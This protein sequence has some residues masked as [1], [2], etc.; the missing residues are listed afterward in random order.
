MLENLDQQLQR[1]RENAQAIVLNKHVDIS[2][3]NG[4]KKRSYEDA[5][6]SIAEAYRPSVISLLET[7][8]Q[9]ISELCTGIGIP[10]LI[11]DC[12]RSATSLQEDLEEAVNVQEGHDRTSS[13]EPHTMNVGCLI[14]LRKEGVIEYLWLFSD[15]HPVNK[16]AGIQEITT[17][18]GA[19]ES[20]HSMLKAYWRPYLEPIIAEQKKV[21]AVAIE[22]AQ[23][24]IT[25]KE[26]TKLLRGKFPRASTDTT[27]DIKRVGKF[28]QEAGYSEDAI[29][30]GDALC[31][32][33]EQRPP[34]TR[35]RDDHI[36]TEC[37]HEYW[38]LEDV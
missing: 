20:F 9:P 8:E 18:T 10:P 26:L 13:S 25:R 12:G 16:D 35:K 38:E 14:T 33:E 6:E 32:L 24:T 15:V 37:G 23:D 22:K 27:W 36:D 19:V 5:K 29:P 21:E 31:W 34:S 3:L 7:Y 28:V 17:T 2:Q 1:E 30:R 4:E 11:M